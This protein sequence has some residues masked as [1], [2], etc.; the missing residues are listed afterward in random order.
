MLTPG[1]LVLDDKNRV[2]ILLGDPVKEHLVGFIYNVLFDQG[3]EWVYPENIALLQKLPE[4]KK[5]KEE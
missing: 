4:K 1:S 2:G 3:P 5:E